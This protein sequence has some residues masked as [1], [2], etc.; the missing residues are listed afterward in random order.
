MHRSIRKSL[1]LSSVIAFGGIAISTQSI[2]IRELL[3]IFYGNELTIGIIFFSWFLGIM[4]GAWISG[5]W[6]Q[7][8]SRTYIKWYPFL[9]TCLAVLSIVSII[10]IRL[11]PIVIS[12]GPGQQVTFDKTLVIVIITV[13]PFSVL[14]GFLFPIITQSWLYRLR[15]EYKYR[16]DLEEAL[17][18]GKIYFY[19]S[20]GSM[21]AGAVLAYL[22]IS[23]FSNFGI[24]F[25]WA[26]IVVAI[27]SAVDL[28]SLEQKRPHPG[29]KSLTT[30][31]VLFIM[32]ISYFDKSYEKIDTYTIEQRW[33]GLAGTITFIT[34]HDTKYQ[35]LTLGKKET[36]YMI[37]ANG[38][39]SGSFPDP[40]GG[41]INAHMIMI[42]NPGAKNILILGMGSENIILEMLR[43][44]VRT[45]DYAVVDPGYFILTEQYFPENYKSI[46]RNPRVK[47]IKKDGKHYV[48]SCKEQYD[49]IVVNQPDPS[50]ANINRYY[51]AEFYAMLKKIMN[52]HG[53]MFTFSTSAINYFSEETTAYMGSLYT[54]LKTAFKK[55]LVTPGEKAMFIASDYEQDIT[56][57]QDTL[58]ARYEYVRI[59]T[60]Y[61]SKYHFHY[62]LESYRVELVQQFL[63]NLESEPVNSDKQP[64]AFFLNLILWEKYSAPR[65]SRFLSF[66][67]NLRFKHLV[68]ALIIIFLFRILFKRAGRN[69]MLQK[70]FD[71]LAGIF[72]AGYIGISIDLLVM[73]Q[74]QSI[75]GFVYQQ[76]SLLVALFMAGLVI[77]SYAGNKIILRQNTTIFFSAMAIFLFMI[78][79]V[80]LLKYSITISILHW[81]YVY[82]VFLFLMILA[83]TATGIYFP[84]ANKIYLVNGGKSGISAGRTDSMD[85][86]G[87]AFGSL[88]TGCFFIPLLGV[89]D[90]CLFLIGLA[91]VMLFTIGINSK[92]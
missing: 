11:S 89:S 82:Y 69:S 17:G 41:A 52:K 84:I 39:Y 62:L 68:V 77:G 48:A 87:A 16:R 47:I 50:N 73:F 58:A 20:L 35:N 57:D 33:K 45:I 23:K 74:F 88:L 78:L 3:V 76:I 15:E 65:F 90:N 59:E 32:V 55:V 54:T 19:E 36:I 40:Y 67:N 6:I 61:F 56:L 26:I 9:L 1:F 7:K 34:S 72:V 79:I 21:F 80:M 22:L 64:A 37:Y 24:M 13:V 31:I 29:I 51:T 44:P 60:E 5:S 91:L 42:Q 46:L 86:L 66:F 38:K 92:K 18:I 70:R 85:H 14:I 10:G 63:N 2:L 81:Q 25:L 75:F 8:K 30:L 49:I 43:Y 53:I 12:I 28:F 83:G 71:A 27:A 4:T